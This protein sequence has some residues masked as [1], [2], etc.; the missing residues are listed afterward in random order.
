MTLFRK[1]LSVM[2]SACICVSVCCAGAVSEGKITGETTGDNEYSYNVLE[3][4]TAEII[5]YIGNSKKVKVPENIDGFTVTQIGDHAFASAQIREVTLPET[6]TVI[7]V[8]AFDNCGEL[9]KITLPKGLKEIRARAFHNCTQLSALNIP[10]GVNAIGS[11]AFSQSDK[12][13]LRVD[14]GNTRFQLIDGVL[15]DMTENRLIWYDP[16]RTT[17]NY[18][19]PEGTAVIDSHA[20]ENN[21][22]L[23]SIFIPDTVTD[24]LQECILSCSSLS[25]VNI[26]D[27]IRSIAD[28]VFSLCPALKEITVSEEHPTLQSKDGVLFSK[29]GTVLICYPGGKNEKEYTV[30]QGVTEIGD[31]AFTDSRL[32]RIVLPEGMK[33]IGSNAFMG[34]SGL[35]E[36]NIPDGTVS[37]ASFAFQNC[38]GLKHISLPDSLKTMDDNPFIRCYALTAV[39]ISEDHP[40]FMLR[41]NALIRKEDMSLIWYPSAAEQEE[42]RIPDGVRSIGGSA[43]HKCKLKSVIVPEGVVSIGSHAFRSCPALHVTLPASVTSIDNNSVFEKDCSFSVVRDSYGQHYC[44]RMGF[45]FTVRDP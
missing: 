11:G 27:S 19:I 24:M 31:A 17:K 9:K 13:K 29:D 38:R 34:S 28:G 23:Q 2:L 25:S 12:L 37:I 43:F 30:P 40:Y 16:A 21:R 41:D 14:K 3:D 10:A 35:S 5:R 44:E 33:T 45:A 22:R 6:V 39:E 18:A 26:P 20:I 42:Y 36:I 15:F 1:L 7:G 4:G 32:E 8:L